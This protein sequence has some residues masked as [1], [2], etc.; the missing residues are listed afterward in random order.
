MLFA[1]AAL[2]APVLILILISAVPARACTTVLVG[3]RASES[4]MVLVGHNEDSGG[5]HVMNTF[6]T[7]ARCHR[8]GETVRF[9]P[10]CAELPLPQESAGLL[11]SEARRPGKE[12]QDSGES[13]CDVFVN[14]N[15]VVVCSDSCVHSRE[16]RPELMEGGIGY[17]LRR[18]VAEEARSAAHAVEVAV[19]LIEKYGYASRGRSYHFADREECWVVQVVNGKHYAVRRVPDDEVYLIPNHYT[20]HQ[21][22]PDTPG[23]QQLMDYARRRGWH[24]PAE[25]PF[26]FAKAYQAPE[27]RGR[28]WNMHRHVRGLEIL[29]ERDLSGLLEKPDELPFSVRPARPVNV[30]TVKKILRT[31]YEGT[32]SDVSEGGSRHFMVTRPICAATTLESTIVEIRPEPDRVLLRR[33]LGRP[34]AAPYMP[35]YMGVSGVPEGYAFGDADA[36]LSNHFA[37]SAADMDWRGDSAWFRTTAVQ[38]AAEL[39]GREAQEAVSEKVRS[40]EV[41]MENELRMMDSQIEMHMRSD[42]GVARAMMDGLLRAWSITV[43]EGMRALLD[44]LGVLPAVSGG[45]LD[46]SGG[47]FTLRWEAKPDFSPAELDP[48]RCLCGPHYLSPE[49]WSCGVSAAEDD[50]GFSVSFGAGEWMRDAVPCLTDLSVLL[51]ERGGRRHAASVRLNIRGVGGVA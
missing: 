19:A 49:K 16:D 42:P 27:D 37:V 4:G 11:W 46:A 34:C 33:A 17:G 18:L 24:D 39:L 45:T 3:R 25:G 22:D 48:E 5:R 38:A 2:C 10:G 40:L 26:D 8:P 1:M 15:G 31:H 36:A 20:I 28:I 29:L 32:A 51:T 14:T 9:E 47:D 43:R 50:A 6:I 41:Q 7:P 12:G 21:P 23:L 13:F 30:D 35:W 44:R